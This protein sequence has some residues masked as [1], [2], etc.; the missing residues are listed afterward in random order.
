MDHNSS[1]E[2]D[3]CTRGF[4]KKSSGLNTSPNMFGSNEVRLSNPNLNDEEREL[5]ARNRITSFDG[6]S[7]DGDE[8][9]E[10]IDRCDSCA[11]D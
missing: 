6:T 7:L 9:D 5:L 11:S 2:E 3:N 8:L 10:E 4:A 1:S